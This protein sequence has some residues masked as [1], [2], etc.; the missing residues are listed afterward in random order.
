MEIRK[1]L[2]ADLP[3]LMSLY[4]R[5]C[6]V[7]GKADFLH[8]GNKGGF[9]SEDMVASAIERAEQFVGIEDGRIAAAYIMDHEC[10]DA[11]DEIPWATEGE[12][13]EI[14]ILHALRVL[15]E[16]GGRGFSKQLVEHAI[17]TARERRPAKDVSLLRVRAGRRRRYHVPRHR[18]SPKVHPLRAATRSVGRR[19]RTLSESRETSP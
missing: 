8:D 18:R 5:M 15:P 12:T 11:Y 19:A 10:D 9:P 14:S 1:A 6:E 16:Y 7:L 3:E 4:S 2:P 17:E 13:H